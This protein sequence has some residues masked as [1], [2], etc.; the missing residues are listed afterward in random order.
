MT[1]VYSDNSHHRLRLRCGK[2][3][4]GAAFWAYRS[5]TAAYGQH[6]TR[7]AGGGGQVPPDLHQPRRAWPAQPQP[8]H[9]TEARRSSELPR[10]AADPGNRSAA[11]VTPLSL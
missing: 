4:R 8:G 9:D 6:V 5:P 11:L 7:N 1:I 10:L 2:A 3:Y